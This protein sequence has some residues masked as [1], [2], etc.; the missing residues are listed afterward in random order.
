MPS[1]NLPLPERP[2]WKGTTV[3]LR[4]PNGKPV[5]FRDLGDI[6]PWPLVLVGSTNPAKA[7]GIRLCPK[8]AAEGWT[9]DE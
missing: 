1:Y 6:P 8:A 3:R 5:E 2:A 7:T 4:K 9:L